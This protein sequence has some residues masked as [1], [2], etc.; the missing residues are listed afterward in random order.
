MTIDQESSLVELLQFA[1]AVAVSSI[2]TAESSL[3]PANRTTLLLQT[4]LADVLDDSLKSVLAISV[5]LHD[6]SRT[7]RFIQSVL[8]LYDI[9]IPNFPLA[10]VI[11]G[12][13]VLNSVLELV[14]R[15]GIEVL[16]LVA[17]LES[18][19]DS[20]TD[21][22]SDATLKSTLHLSTANTAPVELVRDVFDFADKSVMFVGKCS[23]QQGQQGK[24]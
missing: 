13:V 3:S 8:A 21:T 20:T 18:S 16:T 5:V 17:T 10:L 4:S 6:T 7:V 19:A 1:V 14:L 9:S 15:V 12:V 2:S 22:A 11:T 23:S 24:R